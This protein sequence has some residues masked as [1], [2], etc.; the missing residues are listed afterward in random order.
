LGL[1]YGCIDLRQ[2]PDGEYVFFEVNPSG[3][4]LFVQLDTGQPLIQSI[5]KLLLNPNAYQRK[6]IA[7]N[8]I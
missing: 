4:F 1:N 2:K 6:N 5:C 7:E 8:Y 3:Q